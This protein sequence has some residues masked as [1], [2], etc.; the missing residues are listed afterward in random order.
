MKFSDAIAKFSTWRQFK[1]KAQ[2][3]KGYDKEL[4]TFCLFLRNPEVENVSLMDVMDY[5]NGMQELGWKH[6]SF[7]MKCMALRKFFEFFRLQ[8]YRV[9]D[10]ALIPIPRKTFAIPRVLKEEDYRKLLAVIPTNNDPRHF[11]NRA[12]I[13]LLWDSGARNG[14]IVSLDMGDMDYNRQRAV[15]KTEKSRG[16]RP[17]REIFWTHETNESLGRWVEKRAGLQQREPQA[18]FISASGANVGER[19]TIRGVGEALRRYSNRA[20]LPYINPHSFR[21]HMG[22]EIVKR[23]GSAADVM[24]ILG[25]ATLASSSIYTMMTDKELEERYRLF[26]GN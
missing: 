2:T 16:R 20:E 15:I 5:L 4:R 21:H 23:G 7:I 3:V 26:R 24:N 13:N 14:E 6:N 1:V 22:H 18:L 11:R 25:H 8:G 19:L 9:I 10:E 12:I 17:L